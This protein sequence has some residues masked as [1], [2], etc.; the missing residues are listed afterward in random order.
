MA[1]QLELNLFDL[2]D[3][4]HKL[5]QMQRQIEDMHDSFSKVRRKMFYQI[6]EMNKVILS[7]QK[8]NSELKE[9]LRKLHETKTH[10]KENYL[11]NVSEY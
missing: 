10:E 4:D 5:D 2:S 11:F 3:S 7:I 6:A 1:I 9:R 8:E